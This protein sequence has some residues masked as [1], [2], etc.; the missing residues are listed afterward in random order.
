MLSTTINELESQSKKRDILL[1]LKN[2]K[3]QVISDV[4]DLKTDDNKSLRDLIKELKDGISSLSSAFQSQQNETLKLKETI[5]ALTRA[6]EYA[7]AK[8]EQLKSEV[9]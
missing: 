8:I 1:L 5:K 7:N 4:L 6:L 3:L 2:G 9:L